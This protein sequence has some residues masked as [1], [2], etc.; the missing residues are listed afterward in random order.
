MGIKNYHVQDMNLCFQA[1]PPFIEWL[2][3]SSS[4]PIS[5]SSSS[6]LTQQIQHHFTNN[7]MSLFKLPLHYQEQQQQ[8]FSRESRPCLPL[9]SRLSERKCLVREEDQG[10]N[11]KEEEE[12]VEKVTVAL[13]IGLPN[14]NTQSDEEINEKKDYYGKKEESLKRRRLFN[15]YGGYCNF[16]TES[17][18]W[19]PTPA[20]I[21][22]GPMQFVCPICN[23]TF[24]RYNNMQVSVLIYS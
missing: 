12:K 13:H 19:I 9:L 7:M 17:R 11:I 4:P 22:V 20:Q 14:Y 24:N 6:I 1:P 2:K 21:L 23:K 16:N 18:F 10:E 8:E 3:P 15:N 5:S